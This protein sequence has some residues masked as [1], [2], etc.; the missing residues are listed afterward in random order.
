MDTAGSRNLHEGYDLIMSLQESNTLGECVVVAL[1]TN[2]CDGWESYVQKI[3]N[4]IKP[5]HRLV[6][7]TPYDGRWE[8][9]WGSYKT[10]QYLRTLPEKYPFV[11]IADWAA[12]ISKKKS[13]W[14]Q[15][16]Y[17]LAEIQ[18]ELI[19]LLMWLLMQ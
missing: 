11:T 6:F 8:E 13:C 9:D 19:C 14:V 4:D 7:V 16:R 12:T 17:I 2:T 3:I 15:I 5:G 10:T 18:K 1:G